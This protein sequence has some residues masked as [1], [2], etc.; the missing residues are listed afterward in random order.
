[1]KNKLV[2]HSWGGMLSNAANEPEK[3]KN[4]IIEYWR[5]NG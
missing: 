2:G 1:M 5:S 3:I 4:Y